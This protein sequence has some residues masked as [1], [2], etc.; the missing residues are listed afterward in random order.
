MTVPF[1]ADQ[2]IWGERLMRLGV[3]PQSIPFK[4]ISEDVLAEAIKVVLGDE[5]M[6]SLA[7]ELGQK[8]RGEDGVANAV[9]AFHR[10]LGLMA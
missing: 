5:V 6:R 9:E 2:S 8:I 4:K 3:S 10:H 7:Q 1:F